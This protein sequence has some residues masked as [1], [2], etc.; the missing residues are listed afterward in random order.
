ML[1]PRTTPEE[2]RICELVERVKLGK[3][4]AAIA[5][6]TVGLEETS[7]LAARVAV[8]AVVQVQAVVRVVVQVQAVVRVVV[9]V[10]AVARVA[11]TALV[12]ARAL[13]QEVPEEAQ[14]TAVVLVVEEEVT[15]RSQQDHSIQDPHLEV[16]KANPMDRVVVLAPVDWFAASVLN[17][18]I[19]AVLD[20][21]EYK[22]IRNLVSMSMKTVVL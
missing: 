8:R 11:V 18:T 17:L 3:I 1:T 16:V 7:K 10:Q 20:A 15:Q 14:E 22:A 6:A 13:V 4:P 12:T 21:E 2:P 9:Q 5:T 19:P